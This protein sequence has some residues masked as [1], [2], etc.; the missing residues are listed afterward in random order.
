MLLQVR[1]YVL[2]KSKGVVLLLHAIF[3]RYDHVKLFKMLSIAVLETEVAALLEY[4]CRYF[5]D[6][7]CVGINFC[8]T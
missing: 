5:I 6:C 8:N 2:S 3:M 1:H 7:T 4:I